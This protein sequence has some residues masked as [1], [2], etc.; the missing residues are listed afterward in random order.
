V[1]E[2]LLLGALCLVAAS[3]QGF[4]GF[5]YGIVAMST[6]TLFR[7]LEEASG[8]VNLTATLLSLSMLWSEHP[9]VLWRL[10][11]RI[12]PSLLVGIAL[13]LT[14]LASLDRSLM[15]RLLGATVVAVA[16]WNLLSPR[17]SR[18]DSRPLDV[19]AGLVAGLLSGAFNTAGPPLVA[20]LYRRPEAPLDLVVTLQA[21]FLVSCIGRATMATA[22][23]LIDAQIALQSLQ[24]APFVVTGALLG[25]AAARRTEAERFRRVAWFAFGAL[26]VALLLSA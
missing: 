12:A 8:V 6:L 19:A 3:V 7:G 17:L 25:V 1:A 26:G 24:A 9:R 22:Q 21:I 20:H 10:V 16:A 5:G 23:G 11:V 18:R 14:A 15:V 4:L 2:S 13:G